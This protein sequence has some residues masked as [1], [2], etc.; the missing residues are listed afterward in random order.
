MLRTRDYSGVA[1]A[2]FILGGLLLTL[3]VFLIAQIY[4]TNSSPQGIAWLWM[5]AWV[6]VFLSA[7]I[8][9]SPEMYWIVVAEF[10]IWIISQGMAFFGNGNYIL[11]A[12]FL[13]NGIATAFTAA[14]LFYQPAKTEK[15]F[16]KGKWIGAAIFIIILWW[17]L[18]RFIYFFRFFMVTPTSSGKKAEMTDSQKLFFGLAISEFIYWIALLFLKVST[19]QG[20]AWTILVSLIILVFISYNFNSTSSLSASMIIFIAWLVIQYFAFNDKLNNTPSLGILAFYILS[21]GIIMYGLSLWHRSGEHEFGRIYQHWTTIYFLV[22]TYILTFQILLPYIWSKDSAYTRNSLIFLFFLVLLSLISLIV[23]I[24]ASIKSG[25]VE[26]KE[27]GFAVSCIVLLILLIFSASI[28]SNAVSASDGTCYEKQ[29][30]E[31]KDQASC[32]NSNLQTKCQWLNNYCTYQSQNCYLYKE[33]NACTQNSCKWTPVARCEQRSCNK[34]QSQ[35]ACEASSGCKWITSFGTLCVESCGQFTSQNTC[36][37]AQNLNCQWLNNYCSAFPQNCY[38]YQTQ[39]SCEKG[40][41]DWL[42]TGRCDA[43]YNLLQQTSLCQEF[44]NNIDTCKQHNECQWRQN[45]YSY[46]DHGRGKTPLSLWAVWIFANVIFIL[47]I[48]GVI[49]YGTW[50]KLPKVIN[51]GIVFFAV[52]IITRYVGFIMDFWGYTSL[53]LIFITG[54]IIL[55][56]GG[57]FIEKWR[58]NLVTASQTAQSSAQQYNRIRK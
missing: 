44:S 30:Y 39:N 50:Q 37:N 32:T 49:G 1:K 46:W 23:G 15:G 27:I 26:V 22:F 52:D 8:L 35:S 14:S 41:C 19:N 24:V 28:V 25:N 31:L 2:L 40:S 55:L 56:G 3:S 33:E 9:A 57:F 34:R 48:L 4:F 16:H 10:G 11:S 38:N 29:C 20:S 12:L 45:S 17:I 7:Y 13:V 18:S 5:I 6:G 42:T 54:G 43:Q 36:E 21:C 53:A 58:R 47:L 51:L